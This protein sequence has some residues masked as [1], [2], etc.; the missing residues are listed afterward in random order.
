MSCYVPYPYEQLHLSRRGFTSPSPPAH[1]TQ[2][3]RISWTTYY[4]V[5]TLSAS[6]QPARL[7]ST[8]TPQRR[9]ISASKRVPMNDIA[10]HLRLTYKCHRKRGV[11]RFH[12]AVGARPTSLEASKALHRSLPYSSGLPFSFSAAHKAS[13][14]GRFRS[15]FST[16]CWRR[17]C[18]RQPPFSFQPSHSSTFFLW[19]FLLSPSC[20]L[21]YRRFQRLQWWRCGRCTQAPYISRSE[22]RTCSS[23]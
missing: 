7:S 1:N 4:G 21:H 14:I 13:V 16:A 8:Q 2:R 19:S 5:L 10:G 17:H 22:S 23:R 6:F 20:L 18:R 3:A 11:V 12:S 15:W 9:T